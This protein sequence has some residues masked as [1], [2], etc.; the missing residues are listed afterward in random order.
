MGA[1][2]VKVDIDRRVQFRAA[3]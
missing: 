1:A 2:V 3:K